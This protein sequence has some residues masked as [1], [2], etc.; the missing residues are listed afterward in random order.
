M[1]WP[2]SST[3]PRPIRGSARCASGAR[4]PD[5]P[6]LPWAGTTGW[7]PSSRSRSSRSTSNGRQPEWPSASVLA[8]RRSIARTTSRGSAGPTPTAWL[9]RRFSWSRRASAGGM[10]VVARS[11]KPVVIPYTTSPAATSRST[12]ARASSIRARAS[13][14][15]T[16]RAP[17]RATASTSAIVRSAP[18]RT[19][20][21]VREV[22]GV[23]G[24][25]SHSAEHSPAGGHRPDVRSTARRRRLAYPPQRCLRSSTRSSSPSSRPSTAPSATSA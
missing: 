22:G 18:D 19:I 25:I 13:P 1:T 2:P 9:T 24:S 20:G 6:T 11:P 8:R 4:S 15:R 16:A 10:K 14:S 23:R 3:S 12:T 5:A 17:P 21:S 7:I